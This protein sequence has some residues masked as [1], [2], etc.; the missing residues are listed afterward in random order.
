[1]EKG[2][3]QIRPGEHKILVVDDDPSILH[4]LEK[5]LN[6]KGYIA[7]TA[8]S[9]EEAIE[10]C[11]SINFDLILI[12]IYLSG[13]MNGLE[14]MSW[15][16]EHHP[17]L[18]KIVLSG[19]TKVQ[20]VVEAV[21]KSAFDFILKPIESWEVFYHQIERAIKYKVVKVENERLLE[22]L[23][24]KNRELE[25]R[26]AELELAYQIVQAQTEIFQEDLRRAER[27]QRGLLPKQLPHHDKCS[28][29]VFYQPLNKIGGDL[30][31]VFDLD[32]HK[33]GLYIADTSGHGIGSALVTTFLKYVFRP[34][35]PLEKGSCK[36]ALPSE[37][38]RELNDTL[39]NGPF[40]YEMFMSL[41]YIVVDFKEKTLEV[42]NAG[43]PPILWKHIKTN[44]IER[45]RVP[46]PALG[47]VPNAKFSSMK[48][49]WEWGDS[50]I[51]YT[52]GIVNLEDSQGRKFKEDEL[53]NLLEA[54][55]SK[56]ID[57]IQTLEKNL[58][59]Y[60]NSK[61]QKDD[62]TLIYLR[63][64]PQED[65][66]I[67]Y[68]PVEVFTPASFASSAKG[69]LYATK[70]HTCY[71]KIS[72]T[73]TWREAH[74]LNE[75][76]RRMIQE[77]PNMSKWVFDFSE[78]SQ[79]ESTFFGILHLICTTAEKNGS[80]KISLQ[81]IGR[82]LLKEFSELGLADILIHFAFEPENLPQSLNPISQPKSQENLLDFII[83]AH[84][85]L[86]SADPANSD[87]FA[88]LLS[89]LREEKNK[90]ADH[91]P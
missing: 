46:A 83:E 43:H 77:N 44:D 42:C 89:L 2:M 1:M 64:S 5:V 66:Q 34:K 24:N 91:S 26:L 80:P 11:S 22:E 38:L 29:S 32:T 85:A 13:S 60:I 53:V 31:D 28:V 39:V 45:I 40:G 30:F 63:L 47:I 81:N 84:Q 50:I 75:F 37:L 6:K 59:N 56:P 36:I 62:M 18:I 49:S 73:G 74:T 58:S 20:D 27:I 12:D 52:D 70:D 86:I 3:V 90:K 57:V 71:I 8:S 61:L 48:Y 9:A 23:Q 19:T 67:I 16:E 78:C 79:L 33:L 87:R 82:P 25:N 72:G 65:S 7:H 21:H 4:L 14:F 51:L 35:I 15:L 88:Q 55:N 10:K 69:L 76:F 17:Y 68:R 54:N 41:C